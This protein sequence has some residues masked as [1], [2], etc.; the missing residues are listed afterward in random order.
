MIIEKKVYAG[1]KYKYRAIKDHFYDIERTGCIWQDTL[2]EETFLPYSGLATEVS[3]GYGCTPYVKIAAGELCDYKNYGGAL[4]AIA[5]ESEEPYFI[6]L[7]GEDGNLYSAQA[8]GGILTGKVSENGRYNL[9]YKNQKINLSKD[10]KEPFG[11]WSG[12]IEDKALVAAKAYRANFVENGRLIFTPEGLCK[13]FS[14]ANNASVMFAPGSAY[15]S[16]K[17]RMIMPQTNAGEQVLI[18]AVSDKPSLLVTLLAD[19]KVRL[20]VSTNGETY[21]VDV[22][23][24]LTGNTVSLDDG[25][26]YLF[27]VGFNE[28]SYYAAVWDANGFFRTMLAEYNYRGI[29]FQPDGGALRFGAGTEGNGFAGAIDLRALTIDITGK[30]CLTALAAVLPEA[31]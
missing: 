16:V 3:S 18:S 14:A 24:T 12:V 5:P 20:Q 19:G 22:R 8:K 4:L 1:V 25:K 27:E 7:L 21:D 11:R 31:S 26:E 23:D 15:W 28:R 10:E 13:G 2:V 9:F 30:D 6:L 17:F 29:I